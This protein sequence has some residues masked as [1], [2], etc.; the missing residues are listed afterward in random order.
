M[1][2][3]LNRNDQ[4]IVIEAAKAYKLYHAYK[5]NNHPAYKIKES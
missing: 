4:E 2:R 3:G 1:L 5:I